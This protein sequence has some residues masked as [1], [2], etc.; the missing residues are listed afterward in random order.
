MDDSQDLPRVNDIVYGVVMELRPAWRV[1]VVQ[2]AVVL[3]ACAAITVA[4]H[5]R[6][7]AVGLPAAWRGELGRGLLASLGSLATGW[8]VELLTWRLRDGHRRVAAAAGWALA[9]CML[10]FAE[11]CLDA[12]GYLHPALWLLPAAVAGPMRGSTAV[13]AAAL[14][15]PLLVYAGW[16]LVS[17]C[18]VQGTSCTALVAVAA[19]SGSLVP[20]AAN[21][22]VGSVGL[23]SVQAA[24]LFCLYTCSTVQAWRHSRAGQSAAADQKMVADQA[25]LAGGE[26]QRLVGLVAQM[27]PPATLAVLRDA[28][29]RAVVLCRQPRLVAVELV[30]TGWPGA[31]PAAEAVEQL[32]RLV[33][34][35][36]RV[37]LRH[38]RAAKVKAVGRRYCAAVGLGR[39]VLPPGAA[40]AAAVAL[41]FDL[42]KAAQLGRIDLLASSD[43]GG[44]GVAV[45]AV[46]VGPAVAGLIGAGPPCYDCYGDGPA[47]AAALAGAAA[48]DRG[49]RAGRSTL[50]VV[51]LSAQ[52]AAALGG[53]PGF[54]LEP[55]EFSDG[56]DWQAEGFAVTM[57]AGHHDA[58]AVEE[59]EEVVEDLDGVGPAPA[60]LAAAEFSTAVE[61]EAAFSSQPCWAFLEGLDNVAEPEP[62]PTART[63]GLIAEP[64]NPYGAA[65]RRRQRVG[66]AAVRCW[67]GR[68]RLHF[69]RGTGQL[70]LQWRREQADKGRLLQGRRLILLLLAV[71]AT[72]WVWR[73]LLVPDEATAASTAGRATTANGTAF[74]GGGGG[75]GSTQ[76]FGTTSGLDFLQYAGLAMPVAGALVVTFS[77]PFLRHPDGLSGAA[78]ALVAATLGAFTA[79]KMAASRST[80]ADFGQLW[81]W[82]LL[83]YV[84]YSGGLRASRPTAATAVL[85]AGLPIGAAVLWGVAGGLRWG[86]VVLALPSTL[87]VGGQQ[88]VGL[89]WAGRQAFLWEQKV[90]DLVTAA[91]GVGT[92]HRM[93]TSRLMLMLLPPPAM[94]RLIGAVATSGGGG[95][96][97]LSSTQ[98]ACAALSVEIC[99]VDRLVGAD[100]GASSAGSE[101]AAVGLALLH[102]MLAVAEQLASRHGCRLLQP[103]GCCWLVVPLDFG[104][105]VGGA[106]VSAVEVEKR[107]ARQ[108]TPLAAL[109]LDLQEN[110]QAWV[111]QRWGAAAGMGAGIG[112]AM[113]LAVGELSG[114]LVGEQLFR[115]QA[116]GPAAALAAE[117]GS[118]APLGG[119]LTC[120]HARQLLGQPEPGSS[121]AADGVGGG[122]TYEHR[123]IQTDAVTGGHAV[124]LLAGRVPGHP[125][126]AAAAGESRA[127]GAASARM[128]GSVELTGVRSVASVELTGRTPVLTTP[129][130][131]GAFSGIVAHPPST[132]RSSAIAPRPPGAARPPGNAAGFGGRRVRGLA[133]QGS[134]TPAVVREESGFSE[135]QDVLRR[136][137][138]AHLLETPPQQE[139]RR[140]ALVGYR[141]LITASPGFIDDDDFDMAEFV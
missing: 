84:L 94:R 98:T 26:R 124:N 121:S 99:G 11:A 45:A 27:L 64:A 29:E 30:C 63:D 3:G 44:G 131:A 24:S 134:D 138:V 111:E 25:A 37:V 68:C 82:V 104:G 71:V 41:S 127:G 4:A 19:T 122:F 105:A 46:H 76:G 78:M 60:G 133:R 132:T 136:P 13:C 115:Y 107:L 93:E 14:W 65:S 73:G 23:V 118:V 48:A 106:A 137:E 53:Q 43:E 116:F 38:P 77:K 87:L 70:E 6:Y 17:G 128:L 20:T 21:G 33:E 39:E 36:D 40:A 129:T 47:G 16:L 114:A 102:D 42:L 97:L 2:A 69:G 18:A 109:A 96:R 110:M 75:V 120:D 57:L 56:A 1:T 7:V 85:C 113:G 141:S 9:G 119:C 79:A 108:L 86:L 123:S 72:G 126:H 125:A 81:S 35:F 5:T 139:A 54:L 12:A 49:G 62:E 50:S 51:V 52:A 112:T 90:D 117:L 31:R 32:A 103:D 80:E 58:P 22:D 59:V 66:A 28:P 67:P 101:R 8:V 95:D 140:D 74:A 88:V 61:A 130:P 55:W 92:G 135:E 10:T 83:L 89:E 15:L 34:A 91:A 100:D